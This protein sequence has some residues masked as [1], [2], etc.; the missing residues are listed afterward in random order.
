M[1]GDVDR[2]SLV[3][4]QSAGLVHDVVPVKVLVERI[5]AQAEGVIRRNATLIHPAAGSKKGA[6]LYSG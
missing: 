5:V 1:D 2:G 4:G 3:A 6:G